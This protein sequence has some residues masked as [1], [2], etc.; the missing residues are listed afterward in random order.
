VEWLKLLEEEHDNFRAV[1]AWLLEE[2]RTESAVRLAYALLLF[3]YI[4]GHQGEARRWTEEALAK[5]RNLPASARAK[6]LVLQGLMSYGLRSPEQTR[7]LFEEARTLFRGVVDKIG[8]AQATGG[9][10][11]TTL[12]Q[13]SVEEATALFEEALELFREA[14]DKWGV[15]SVLAHLGAIPLGQ[16]NH[17]LAARYFEEALALT[18]EIGNMISGY[19][20]LYNLAL[21]AQ[22]QGDHKRAAGLYVEG[23]RYA[24][25]AGDKANTAYCLEGLAELADARGEVQRAVK[26]FGAAEALL[27][28]A[29][30]ALYVQAQDR[31][32]RDQ[33]VYALRS[34][35]DETAFA[36]AWAEGRAM[37]PDQ[38][39]EYA[40]SEEEP[41]SPV[42][43]QSSVDAQPNALTGREEEVTILVAR[44]RTNRQ[45]ATE[46][47][48]SEH[49]VANH[50]AKILRKLE[51]DSRSQI[52]AWVI[53]R[54]T[55]P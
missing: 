9:M 12:Q 47:S 33:A 46:L 35:L 27:E 48:I 28:D 1:M 23:L 32:L 43:E 29:G 11:L 10:G 20:S 26:L 5:G 36:A 44:G 25:E 14:G 4:H 37:T 42:P 8:W 15:S 3:W 40:L 49:T 51:L 30:G 24:V 52:T 41:F 50:V 45:I 2:G 7:R 16:G 21:A 54:R 22:G 55:M 38:A 39:A 18:R 6:A 17:T 34:R 31:S 13:G 53:E 19:V